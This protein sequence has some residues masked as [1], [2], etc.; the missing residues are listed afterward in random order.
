MKQEDVGPW[1]NS[2]VEDET[3]EEGIRIHITELLAI[4]AFASRRCED[5]AGKVC[6]L[7]W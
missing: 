2:V 4:V 7:C 5:W 3:D 1:L 6:D